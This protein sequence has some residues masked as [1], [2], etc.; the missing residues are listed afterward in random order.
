MKTGLPVK[1]K[2]SI[3]QWKAEASGLLVF[4]LLHDP[5]SSLIHRT[6]L[7]Q[8]MPCFQDNNAAQ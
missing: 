5:I 4:N 1:L 3:A 2:G 8:S 7:P 6:L